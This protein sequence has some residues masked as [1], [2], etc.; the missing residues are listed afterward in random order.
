[1]ATP[2]TEKTGDLP[3]DNASRL[4]IY[5]VLYERAS[6]T[7]AP[8]VTTDELFER[9]IGRLRVLVPR[10][11]H[12]AGDRAYVDEKVDACMEAGIVVAK[13]DN[14]QKSLALTG[15]P[16]LVRY[17]DGEFRDYPPGLELARERL[18]GDNARLRTAGFDVRKSVP[19]I[20][21]DPS[22]VE[23]QALLASMR[24]HGFLKQFPVVKYEDGVVVD[25]RARLRAAAILELDIEYLKYSEKELKAARRRDTPLNRVLVAVHSNQSRLPGDVVDAVYQ[26]VANVTRRTWDAMAADLALTQEW[27]LSMSPDYSPRFEVKKLAYREGDEP[28]IQVT[29]DGKV[30]LRSLLEAGGLSNYKI[31]TQLR[32]HVPFERARSPYTAGPKAVFAR[33]EDLIAGIAAMQQ[34]RRAAKRKVDPEWEQIRQWLVRTFDP[35]GG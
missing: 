3:R 5:D 6:A 34:E 28:K 27:R 4:A 31:G 14:G 25:G 16:P 30:M 24:E 7:G 8:W 33:A 29:S 26:G 17:P 23:F 20:A 18:D 22:G 2:E 13:S 11:L 35:A 9:V 32:D 10:E 15:K 21:D 19:S 1:M 12:L